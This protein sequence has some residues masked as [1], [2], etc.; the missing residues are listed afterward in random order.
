VDRGRTPLV[1]LPGALDGL[2]GADAVPQRLGAD[3]PLVRVAY[4]PDDTLARLHDRILANASEAGAT[5]FDLLGQS[6]GGWVAQCLARLEPERVRRMVLSHSFALRAGDGWKF[7][8]AGTLLK[9][10]PLPLLRPLLLAR[11]RSALAPLRKADPLLVERQLAALSREIGRATF[12][13]SLV[14]QQY[15]MRESLA[16]AAVTAPPGGAGPPVL[17]I[18]SDNDTLIGARQREALRAR[19]PTAAVHRFA[20][21]GHVSAMVETEACLEVVGAFLDR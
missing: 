21:A 19:H 10:M 2:E 17:I 5:R 16:L 9:R 11:A 1:F 4:R 7:R 8:L 15:C 12:R 20:A 14:A 3:R 13:E 6:Y 18:E